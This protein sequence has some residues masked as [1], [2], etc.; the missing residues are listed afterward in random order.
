[1]AGLKSRP[2]KARHV[3]VQRAAWVR[4]EPGA[5]EVDAPGMG[6]AVDL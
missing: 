4:S 2:F 5:P 1:M 3:Q 6:L